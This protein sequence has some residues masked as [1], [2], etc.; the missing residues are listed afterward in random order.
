MGVVMTNSDSGA[1]AVE[2]PQERLKRIQKEREEQ[3]SF[4]R[5]LLTDEIQR[6]GCV[7][8]LRSQM[9]YAETES[10]SRITVESFTAVHSISF[11]ANPS[12]LKMGSEMDFLSS[13]MDDEGRVQ[14]DAANAEEIAQRAPDWTRQPALTT[15]LLSDPNRKF[16][17]LLAVVA[18]RWIDDPK[19]DNWDKDGRAL[20]SAIEFE[21][22]DLEGNIA[23]IDIGRD[24]V[25]AYALDGQHRIMGI[26]GIEDLRNGQFK[27]RNKN[28]DEKASLPR[29]EFLER[30][31]LSRLDLDKIMD[32]S[33][34]V[35]YIPA[36]IKG[37]TA[38]QA[39]QRVRSVFVA[40][41]SKAQKPTS[42]ETAL[43]DETNGFAIVARHISVNHPLLQKK[44]GGSRVNVK[45]NSISKNSD[46]YT[47]LSTIISI[48][49]EYLSSADLK[50]KNHILDH[51]RPYWKDM[52][53]VRP[54]EQEI[55]WGQ[56]RVT[57][58]FDLMQK[59]PIFQ[60]LEKGDDLTEARLIPAEGEHGQ[61]HLLLRPVGQIALARAVGKAQLED[62]EHKALEVSEIASLLS[63]LD[64][65]DAFQMHDPRNLWF[66]V[67]ITPKTNNV[68]MAGMKLAADILLY[69]LR[70]A[71]QAKRD[72]LLEEIKDLRAND[73]K[74]LWRN[75]DGNDVPMDDTS[76]G[77]QLPPPVK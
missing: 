49:D 15:Y 9:G 66:G 35:E 32:E 42:G 38:R 4:L 20:R 61:G 74:T 75:F 64:S 17:S 12:N 57:D 18:P 45:N 69:L 47:T 24:E 58:F 77:S 37:E 5:Q 16:G 59:L 48:C 62:G 43:L 63:K 8:V 11:I 56:Q 27:I 29:Q 54:P 44:G 52:V 25:D 21:G 71:S 30:F 73:R 67:L 1:K 41:N 28:G 68:R 31:N 72:Q 60:G 70:G 19:S 13:Y 39:K 65:K 34:V 14:I 40:I 7:P 53:P 76:S 2:S 46:Y 36:V 51:W 6:K 10:G 22:L 55:E 50:N 3:R 26:R 33:M 23:L